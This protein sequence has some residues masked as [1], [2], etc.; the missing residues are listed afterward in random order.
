MRAV[1]DQVALVLSGGGARAA[2]QVGVLRGISRRFP[3]LAPPILTGVSAGAINAAFLAAHTEP[4]H[5]KVDLLRQMWRDLR[6]DDVFRVDSASLARNVARTGLRLVSGG[7]IRAPRSSALVDTSPLREL[8]LRS[9]A[10]PDGSLSGIDANL[11]R[12]TLRSVAI[13]AS[14]YTTGRSVT[15]FQGGEPRLWDRDHRVGEH[16]VLTVDHVLASASLPLF[17]PAVQVGGRWYGDGGIR[18]TAPLS[19]AIHLGA[20]RI[21]AISTR[22]PLAPVTADGES[23]APYPPPA[24]VAGTLMNA[25]FLDSFD[26]DA[27][28]A[29][30]VNDLLQ[31]WPPEQRGELRPLDLF[32]MR[33]SRDLGRLA[34]EFEPRLPSAFRFMTR[35]W[36]TKEARSNDFLSMVMFQPDYIAGLIAIGEADVSA[37]SEALSAFLAR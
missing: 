23:A 12:G 18:L 4:F 32:V 26:A 29:R 14:C 20:S 11:A 34:D 16:A 22:S 13:T 30:R 37:R 8:L 10:A 17:F 3:D 1:S 21:L 36:G 2:Y 6:T 33:P 28:S 9:M 35:G 27:L 31:A 24:Q 19:P 15:W 25:V 5:A 7:L